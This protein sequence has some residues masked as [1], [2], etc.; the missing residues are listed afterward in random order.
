MPVLRPNLLLDLV[1]LA[2]VPADQYDGAVLGELE[3]G[4]AADAGRRPGN[5]PGLPIRGGWG[6]LC[7]VGSSAAV[8]V[9]SR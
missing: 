6:G 7:H 1:E 2:A 8:R 4:A 3:R 5:D 9:I